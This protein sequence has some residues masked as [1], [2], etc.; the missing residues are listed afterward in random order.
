MRAALVIAGRILR[1][2]LRDRSAILFAVLTPLGLAIAFAAIIPD[3]TPDL[4][5]D[6]RGRRPGR[7]PGRR[8]AP[9][10]GPGR[11]RRAGHRRHRDRRPTRRPPPPRSTPTGPASRSSSRPA[12]RTP[13]TDR[14]AGRDADH[15]RRRT[16]RPGGGAGGR[17]ALRRRHRGGP[18]GRR[19]R[20][21]RAAAR[22]TRR[23]S[24]RATAAVQAPGP[25]AVADVAAEKRQASMAT[26]YGAA[27]AIMFVFFATQY[28]ALGA[29][30][31]ATRRDAQPAAR[32]ADPPGGDH[33]RR[34]ARRDGPGHRRDDDDGRR[35]DP[36]RARELGPAGARGHPARW[37][38][39]SPRPASPRSSSTLAKTV[40]QASGLNAIVALSPGGHRRRLHP[41][42][43][44]ARAPAA[45]SRSSRPHAWFLRAIDTLAVPESRSGRDPAV[46]RG[47]AWRWAS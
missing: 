18:A 5:H 32:G 24:S 10:R 9:R 43:P 11:A 46:G 25:I 8:R 21:P 20:W 44:G 7:R 15:R 12:S 37:R 36:A 39:S 38:R 1:Q 35:D 31:R 29:A 40:E 34:V 16:S 14:A 33:A 27:M 30:R 42:Q 2:R 26:F 3:F 19:G 17:H 4:P 13:S 23:P 22:S 41:A 28:G 47:A 45:G 6:D